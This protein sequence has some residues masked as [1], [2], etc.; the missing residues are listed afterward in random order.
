[1][2]RKEINIKNN[3]TIKKIYIYEN[4]NIIKSFE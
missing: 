1:M 4:S 2:A 3:I